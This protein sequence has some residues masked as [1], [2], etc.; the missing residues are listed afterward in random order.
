MIGEKEFSKLIAQHQNI[1]HKISFLYSEDASE[2]EDLFQ[3]ICLQL[4]RSYGGFQGQSKFSTWLYRVSLNT[5]ISHM[6]KRSDWLT[7]G[8]PTAAD[9]IP[10]KR[11][12]IDEDSMVLTQAISKLNRIDRAVILLWLE[13]ETYAEIAHILGITESNVSVKLVRIKKKIKEMVSGGQ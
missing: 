7:F 11:T 9:R 6:R 4:W 12:H 3:E 2:R 10:S 5:A 1:I 13:G 8:L